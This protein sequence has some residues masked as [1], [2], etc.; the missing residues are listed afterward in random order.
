MRWLLWLLTSSLVLL[1]AAT[2]GSAQP[3]LELYRPTVKALVEDEATPEME[4]ADEFRTVTLG[5][6]YAW[7]DEH[8]VAFGLTK[9]AKVQDGY[10]VVDTELGQVVGFVGA[11]PR[12]PVPMEVMPAEEAPPIAEEFCRR[13]LPEL[14][15]EGGEASIEVEDEIT[16]LGA[17]MVHLRRT[18]QGV[19][20]P[21]LA[22]VGVRVY[23]GKVVYLRRKHV[24]L[25][26]ELELPGAVTLDRAKEIATASV[27]TPTLEPVLW[28]DVE[29]EIIVAGDSQR[30]V[31]DVW[32]ELKGRDSGN[33][34]RL[35]MFL[36]CQVDAST[37]EV[38]RKELLQPTRDL[39]SRYIA[40]G[41]E[42]VPRD[43]VLPPDPAFED[44]DPIFAADGSRLLF[45]STR[46]RDGYPAWL[47]R[48]MGLFVVNA[49]GS[50]LKCLAAGTAIGAGWS[51][52]GQRICCLQPP[53]LVVL[54][55]KGEEVARFAPTPPW[56]YGGSVCL[57]DGKL[58]AIPTKHAIESRLLLLDAATPQAEPVE[59]AH[60]APN[61]GAMPGSWR[62][63]IAGCCSPLGTMSA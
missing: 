8:A 25:A 46:P 22:D 15:A 35:E 21:T 13:H 24:P 42:H 23:D 20:V 3:A 55:L 62:T 56:Q 18:V 26:A 5:K 36:H 47:H 37:E 33:P 49:D 14:F 7:P 1:P 44:S 32:A 50:D 57:P 9:P 54:D 17:R 60:V 19:K 43:G 38:V 2:S 52:D 28:F 48:P 12:G 63:P 39:Y 51:A 34:S 31:W 6:E 59:L 61:P 16:S 4:L 11:E 45:T 29:H 30:N 10:A 41:G 27:P 58:V 40:A 53:D